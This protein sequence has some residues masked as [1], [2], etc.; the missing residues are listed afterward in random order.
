MTIP[1]KDASNVG[2]LPILLFK[3]LWFM[4]EAGQGIAEYYCQ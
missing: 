4:I 3:G 2:G 1:L